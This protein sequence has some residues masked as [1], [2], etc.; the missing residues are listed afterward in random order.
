ME[1]RDRGTA[2]LW[3]VVWLALAATLM[4]AL[5]EVGAAARDA[6]RAQSA[7]DA[8]A[9]AG[10]FDGFDGAR[11]AAQHN[12]AVLIEHGW[13]GDRFV[14]VVQVGEVARRAV[15]VRGLVPARRGP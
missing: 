7:A 10:A 12:D 15:A 1:I 13:T 4:V 6:A 9:L 2:T 8:A 5:A 3:S 14:V 11:D